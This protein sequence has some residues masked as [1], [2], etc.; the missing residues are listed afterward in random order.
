MFYLH[1]PNKL[2]F[3]YY[4]GIREDI[5]RWR[6]YRPGNKQYKFVSNWKHFRLQGEHML[7][8][9]G[10]YVVVTKSQ[11]D[12]MVLYELGIPAVAPISENLFLTDSKYRKLK[13]R[14]GK[15]ILF[16]DNDIAGLTAMQKIRKNHD[17]SPI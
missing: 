10:D 3:G 6:I 8:K 11:K 13:E 12:A 4:G 14:F 7:P 2:V 9:N 17:V 5:E 1:N 15:I 16:Y